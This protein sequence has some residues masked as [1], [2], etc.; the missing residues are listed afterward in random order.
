MGGKTKQAPRTKNNAKV[1]RSKVLICYLTVPSTPHH[2]A[3]EQ[4]PNSRAAGQFHAHIRGILGADG[5]R[6]PGA[7]CSGIRQRRTNAGQL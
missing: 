5:R 2:P 4:Q 7:I 1:R 3:L 6:W